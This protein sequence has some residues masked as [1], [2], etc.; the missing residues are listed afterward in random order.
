MFGFYIHIHKRRKILNKDTNTYN[1]MNFDK[2]YKLNNTSDL[3][4]QACLK[5]ADVNA[6][7][8]GMHAAMYHFITGI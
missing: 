8:K 1:E 7:I 2:N 5:T 6:K 3:H 4:F